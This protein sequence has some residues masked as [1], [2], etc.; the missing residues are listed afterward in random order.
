MYQEPLSESAAYFK[1]LNVL[2]S[3]FYVTIHN[4]LS[5]RLS[6]TNILIKK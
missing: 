2:I 4:V 3:N 1:N 6:I 5:M